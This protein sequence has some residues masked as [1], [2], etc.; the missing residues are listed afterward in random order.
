MVTVTWSRLHD[1]DHMLLESSNHSLVTELVNEV[2]ILVACQTKATEASMRCIFSCL[3][4][5]LCNHT[6]PYQ[7]HI[8]TT[9]HHSSTS[10]TATTLQ[11][12]PTQA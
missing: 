3:L 9:D 2:V 8:I 12:L 5:S 11:V 1:P 4:L 10:A 6:T 7:H